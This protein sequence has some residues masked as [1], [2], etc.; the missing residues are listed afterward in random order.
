MNY[1]P[2]IGS[3]VRVTRLCKEYNGKVG[4]VV[5]RDGEYITV[6]LNSPRQNLKVEVYPCEIEEVVENA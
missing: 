5:G 3:K 4:K 1:Y 6:S 2:K